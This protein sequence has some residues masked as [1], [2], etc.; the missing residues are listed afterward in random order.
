V[1]YLTADRLLQPTPFATAFAVRE[2]LPYRRKVL[3]RWLVEH[4]VGRLEIK[5][6]GLD[7]DPAVLRREL[8]PA[9]PEQATMIISRTPG[10]AVVAVAE[11]VSSSS[12]P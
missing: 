3:R 10:S 2:R 11:R 12:K 5:C 4:G 8:R 6:R 9:G 1:A 7:L